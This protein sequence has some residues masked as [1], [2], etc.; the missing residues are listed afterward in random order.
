MKVGMGSTSSSPGPAPDQK[1]I[2]RM[3]VLFA[4]LGI[5]GVF[6]LAVSVVVGLV[7]LVVA[8]VFFFRAYRRFAGRGRSAG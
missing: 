2:R 5:V 4:V 7:V 3:L 1:D 8:E 6:L